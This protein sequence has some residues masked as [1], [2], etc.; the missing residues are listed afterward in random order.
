MIFAMERE[1]EGGRGGG[2]TVGVCWRAANI[3]KILKN[4]SKEF[5]AELVRS[6][7]LFIGFLFYI[8][9]YYYYYYY[10]VLRNY[11]LNTD[12]GFARYVGYAGN[13][14]ISQRRHAINVDAESALYG[15]HVDIFTDYLRTYF[16]QPSLIVTSYRMKAQYKRNFL[17]QPHCSTFYKNLQKQ[18]HIFYMYIPAY[19]FTVLY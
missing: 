7:S 13:L 8:H 4:V 2:E 6:T 1:R 14:Q 9:Y 11:Y 12:F 15:Q 3:W 16:M 5:R 19:N 10:F 18:K 17:R